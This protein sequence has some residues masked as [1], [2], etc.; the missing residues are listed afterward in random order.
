MENQRE[1]REECVEDAVR[2]GDVDRNEGDDRF[3]QEKEEGSVDRLAKRGEEGAVTRL[4]FV[5]GDIVSGILRCGLELPRAAPEK[6]RT[7]L[8]GKNGD[9][10]LECEHGETR[11]V[12]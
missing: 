4:R 10:Q 8:K 9:H 7:V 5:D 1:R 12:K 3:G 11:E 6:G 2:D